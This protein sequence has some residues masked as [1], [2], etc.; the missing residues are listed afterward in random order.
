MHNETR[1]IEAAPFVRIDV[2]L[3]S[4]THGTNGTIAR[5]RAAS[6]D[7]PNK[8]NGDPVKAM[9][10]VVTFFE[11]AGSIAVVYALPDCFYR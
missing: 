7:Q 5:Q 4:F 8:W 1:E 6:C 3:L 10:F 9:I 2:F 11:K